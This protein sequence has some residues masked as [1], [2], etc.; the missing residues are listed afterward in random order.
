[1]DLRGLFDHSQDSTALDVEAF[2]LFLK[3]LYSSNSKLLASLELGLLTEVFIISNQLG[4]KKLVLLCEQQLIKSVS[5]KNAAQLLDL[6][7][8]FGLSRLE[9]QCEIMRKE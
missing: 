1:M 6:A 8:T 7:Q 9:R 4:V 3:W 2:S 5:E